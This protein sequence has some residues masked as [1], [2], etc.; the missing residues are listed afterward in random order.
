MKHQFNNKVWVRSE[1]SHS[2]SMSKNPPY[3]PADSKCVDEAQMLLDDMASALRI[4]KQEPIEHSLSSFPDVSSLFYTRV[5][6]QCAIRRLCIA[7]KTIRFRSLICALHRRLCSTGRS[8]QRLV[9]THDLILYM[10][11]LL[12]RDET[13]I[14]YRWLPNV[15]VPKTNIIC[16]KHRFYSP[17][18]VSQPIHRP[19]YRSNAIPTPPA[20]AT[21]TVRLFMYRLPIC[22]SLLRSGPASH[23]CTSS[24][25]HFRE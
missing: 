5:F 2:A 19:K 3:R 20:T 9:V 1:E 11:S 17:H 23:F 12:A 25:T 16:S 21:A 24:R 10:Y 22:I 6:N 15:N 8:V 18:Y 7:A 4:P 13:F 14:A